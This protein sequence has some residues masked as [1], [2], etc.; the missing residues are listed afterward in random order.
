[1]P[2]ILLRREV[3]VGFFGLSRASAAACTLLA[4]EWLTGVTWWTGWG[5]ARFVSGCECTEEAVEAEAA[6]EPAV[7]VVLGGLP[8]VGAAIVPCFLYSGCR[9][10]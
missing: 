8:L 4:P 2:I 1:M 5:R 6:G 3:M 7:L 10:G 9:R